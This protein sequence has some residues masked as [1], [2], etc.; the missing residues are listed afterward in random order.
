MQCCFV[1]CTL[2]N[3]QKVHTE[4]RP[5]CFLFHVL[6]TEQEDGTHFGLIIDS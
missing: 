4:D 2:L 5:Y 1:L 6:C 3:I